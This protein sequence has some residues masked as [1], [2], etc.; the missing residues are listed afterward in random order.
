MMNYWQEKQ[1]RLSHLQASSEILET[2]SG[3][4]E[5]AQFGKGPPVLISHGGG[6]GYDMGIWLGRLIGEGYRYIA[7]SRFGYLRT[8][9]SEDPTPE[10]QADGFAHLLDELSI[11]SVF[12][13]G[14][15]SGGPSA[16]QFAQRHL[17]RC[18]GLVLLSAISRS[19]PPLPLGLRMLYPVILRSDFI[20]WLIYR[21]QPNLV[22]RSNGINPVLL[23]E[24]KEDPEKI[25]LLDELFLTI[26][27][28]SL[29]RLGMI[30]D[31]QQCAHLPDDFLH[32]I[33][34]PTQ[35]IHA[36]DD[37]IVPFEF[38]KLSA[39]RIV[40]ADFQII[41]EGGHFCAVTHREI[42]IPKIRNFFNRYK[43]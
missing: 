30:N 32:N 9:L 43:N 19:L 28:A 2:E 8:P 24:V 18:N 5:V 34:V 20:P 33:Q 13:L 25:I 6:G 21:I 17:D 35:V 27:P 7:P 12:V 4:V 42:I 11:G 36:I 40:D 22:H 23:L 16:L 39:E 31:Q 26:F 37:P 3:Y 1:I 15:S 41:P 29:R 10:G 14:L 38:G